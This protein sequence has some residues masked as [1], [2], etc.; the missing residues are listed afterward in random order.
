MNESQY[1]SDGDDQQRCTRRGI[2]DAR[3]SSEK[4]NSRESGGRQRPLPKRM[5]QSKA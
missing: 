3:R 1:E 5:K 4:E 2:A